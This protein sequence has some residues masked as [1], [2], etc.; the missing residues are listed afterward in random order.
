MF[1]A[2]GGE[3]GYLVGRLNDLSGR[4]GAADPNLWKQVLTALKRADFLKLRVPAS[5]K[6][7][8]YVD[9]PAN[10]IA[11]NQCNSWFAIK[12]TSYDLDSVGLERFMMLA[13]QLTRL[14]GSMKWRQKSA[15]AS[16]N[17]VMVHLLP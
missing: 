12:P 11:V 2:G 7:I 9:G 4:Y 15:D 3:N 6:T 17:D 14:T 5:K 13:D 16:I 10:Q 1:G 8:V